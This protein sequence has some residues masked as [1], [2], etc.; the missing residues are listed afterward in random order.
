MQWNVPGYIWKRWGPHP[1]GGPGVFLNSFQSLY[2]M[3]IIT[4]IIEYFLNA[5]NPVHIISVSRNHEI[6]IIILILQIRR[7]ISWD[8]VTCQGHTAPKE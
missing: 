6:D 2:I 4:I 7:Q 5:T 8:A 3:V 1:E